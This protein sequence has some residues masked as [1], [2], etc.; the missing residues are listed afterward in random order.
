MPIG[1]LSPVQS[2]MG[3]IPSERIYLEFLLCDA[4]CPA[5]LQEI[6]FSNRERGVLND[7][8]QQVECRF[9]LR[10]ENLRAHSCG[11]EVNPRPMLGTKCLVATCDLCRGAC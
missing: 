2:Q 9:E 11:V 5:S 10:R 4:V 1:V 6:D 7:V 8:L 3:G